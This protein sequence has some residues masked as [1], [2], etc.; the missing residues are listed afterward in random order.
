MRLEAWSR[1]RIRRIEPSFVTYDD[2]SDPAFFL[3]VD[4][5]LLDTVKLPTLNV[6][7]VSPA[8]VDELSGQTGEWDT[9]LTFGTSTSL[10]DPKLWWP[11]GHGS[12]PLYRLKIRVLDET[13]KALFDSLETR[14]GLRT[15]ELDTSPDDIGRK[16]VVR[17][18]GK[19]I[20]CKGFNWIPD[21]CFLD[22]ACE[23]ERVRERIG[24]AIDAGGNMLRVWG[25][26]IFETDDFYDICDELGVLVWQDFLFACAMYPEEQPFA[27]EVEAEARYNVARLAHHPSLAIWNGCNENI[28]AY[29]NW[30]WREQA[31]GRAG[32]RVLTA[33]SGF[34]A[35]FGTPR[36]IRAPLRPIRIKARMVVYTN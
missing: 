17:V 4:L 5:E 3:D 24:Q 6:E 19:P 34:A 29:R 16:F 36:L 22:R 9:S 13:E 35:Q 27:G 12:Q 18:N 28:W 2:K 15:V 14:I 26:G 20:F 33:R 11:A 21:D 23:R 30:G 7:L 1:A 25:G 10:S 31:L 32:F 8:G